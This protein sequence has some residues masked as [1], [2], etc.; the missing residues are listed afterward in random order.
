MSIVRSSSSL[1]L[2][3]AAAAMFAMAPVSS[4][5]ASENVKCM[6]VNACKGHGTCKT[7]SSACKGQN[8]CKGQGFVVVSADACQQLGGKAG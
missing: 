7:A 8:A 3:A 4:S 6:G 2:A 5:I 1:A